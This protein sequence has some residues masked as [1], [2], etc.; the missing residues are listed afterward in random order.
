MEDSVKTAVKNHFDAYA[1]QWSSRLSSHN[2][3]ARFRLVGRLC[4]E[5]VDSVVDLGCGTGDYS[6]LF[7]GM[8]RYVGLD[9]STEMIKTAKKLYKD[10]EFLVGDVAN[11]DLPSESFDLGLAIG[12]FEY[13]E[14]PNEVADELHRLVENN[15]LLICSFPNGEEK[16]PLKIPIVSH[17]AR[18]IAR[19]LRKLGIIP[20]RRDARFIPP[21]YSK[22]E[23]VAHR[24]FTVSE[25]ENI[26]AN[27]G[28]TVE[29][30]RFCNFRLIRYFIGNDVLGLL[31][32]LLSILIS[33]LW[34]D[35]AFSR[36]ASNSV[37]RLRKHSGS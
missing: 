27:C 5:N 32:K 16:T 12:L 35:R 20:E 14:F 2:Y 11:T 3:N 4:P 34:L 7:N 24:R 21:N 6:K 18:L 37:V 10:Q 33:I 29:E 19:I 13:L 36:F 9:N 15:G 25:I 17:F 26:F 28:V 22:P 31:D 8:S 30:I 23:Q 1:G